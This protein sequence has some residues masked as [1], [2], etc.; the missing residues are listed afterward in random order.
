MDAQ[1]TST[2]KEHSV[3][4]ASRQAQALHLSRRWGMGSLSEAFVD[5]PRARH[6]NS[7]LCLRFVEILPVTLSPDAPRL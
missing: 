5:G 2:G 3:C 1:Q 7:K 4:V 6:R